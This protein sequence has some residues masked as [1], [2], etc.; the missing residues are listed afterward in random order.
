MK[1]GKLVFT[2]ASVLFAA[3][4]AAVVALALLG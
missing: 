2:A 3:F 1:P 4:V